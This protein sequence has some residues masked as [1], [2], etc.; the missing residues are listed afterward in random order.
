MTGYAGPGGNRF[1]NADLIELRQ[2]LPI[3]KP[4]LAAGSNVTIR[5]TSPGV[6]VISSTAAGGGGTFTQATVDFGGPGEDGTATVNVPAPTVAAAS[7]I[8]CTPAAI[9]TADHDPEDYAAEGI[10]AYAAN[11]VAGVGFDII[12]SARTYTWGRYVINAVF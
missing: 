6:W 9:A 2:K 10:T 5:E 11:I 1:D 7:K 3:Q 12:A 8:V 4:I